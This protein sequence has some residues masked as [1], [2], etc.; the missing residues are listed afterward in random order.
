MVKINS[1]SSLTVANRIKKYDKPNEDYLLLDESKNI[2]AIA[3]GVT[4]SSIEGSYPK[5]SPAA[6]TAR[7]LCETVVSHLGK[8]TFSLEGAL[9]ESAAVAN[10]AIGRFN[11]NHSFDPDFLP[12]TVGVW[13]IYTKGIFHY[14]FI[15]DCIASI[16]TQNMCHRLTVSQT[17]NLMVHKKE[18]SKHYIRTQI[19]NNPD[20]PY[21]YG[22][23]NG[24]PR[25][26]TFVQTG[27][28]RISAGAILLLSS[29]GLEPWYEYSDVFQNANRSVSEI[30]SQTEQLEDLHQLRADDKTIIKIEFPNQNQS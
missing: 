16:I 28:V 18:F 17:A 4:R 6:E 21:A 13:G 24:D 3:D 19:C 27:K 23:L 25:A 8:L 5:P 29:D 22:V 1:V 26:L 10:Q 15:G 30:F 9:T 7:I 11:A 14:A 20:H 12:G 2:F